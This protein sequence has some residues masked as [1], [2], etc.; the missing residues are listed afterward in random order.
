[1]KFIFILKYKCSQKNFKQ[2]IISLLFSQTSILSSGSSDYEKRVIALN[3]ELMSLRQLLSDKESIIT[4]LRID[5]NEAN[6][7]GQKGIAL[8]KRLLRVLW[9]LSNYNISVL[10]SVYRIQCTD[11]LNKNIAMFLNYRS[12]GLNR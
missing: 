1:M 12:F 7:K 6:E 9:I 11:T 4:K 5:F 8:V 10:Y 2:L 3:E